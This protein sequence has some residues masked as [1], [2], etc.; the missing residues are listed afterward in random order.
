MRYINLVVDRRLSRDL[1]ELGYKRVT[2]EIRKLVNP[3]FDV[4]LLL[5][6]SYGLNLL[7][8]FGPTF[9]FGFAVGRH[10]LYQHVESAASAKRRVKAAYVVCRKKEYNF[11][12]LVNLGELRKHGGGYEPREKFVASRP[13]SSHLIELIKE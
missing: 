9:V 1:G 8:Q 5:G 6:S 10:D 12:L 7:F 3:V 11:A 13:I 4:L 2:L